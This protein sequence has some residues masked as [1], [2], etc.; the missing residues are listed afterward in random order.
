MWLIILPSL[1]YWPSALGKDAF[2]MLAMGVAS[3]GAACLL[4]G[5]SRP[6]LVALSI[7]LA[8]MCM[9]RPHVAL[10]V[11]AG[12]ALATLVRRYRGGFLQ[13]L[14]AVAFVV[15]AGLVVLQ[16]ASSFF[17]I[18]TFSRAAIQQEINGVGK[19]TAE[20]GSSFSPV[21]VTSPAKFPLAA[22]TVLYRPLPMEAHSPQ[23][24][25]TA[26]EDTV[27]ILLSIRALPRFLRSFKRFRDYPYLA[28]SL[29]AIIVFIIAFSGFSNFG[30]LARERTAIEPLLIVFLT[31]PVELPAVRETSSATARNVVRRR[32]SSARPYR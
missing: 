19:Q 29:G 4:S 32:P 13:A 9:V 10:I 23:E 15:I 2:M 31:L 22:V 12:L 27:L 6:G 11:C 24:M 25:A 7:G 17:G 14:V 16:L 20:G 5:R 1:V 18:A 30:L 28:Y 26:L 8:G 3:Y 21:V